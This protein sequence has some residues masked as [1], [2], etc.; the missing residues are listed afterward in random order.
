MAAAD[1]APRKTLTALV[2]TLAAIAVQ[3]LPIVAIDLAHIQTTSRLGAAVAVAVVIAAALVAWRALPEFR[4]RWLKR[5]SSFALL[6]WACLLTFLLGGS[7]LLAAP[8]ELRQ[9]VAL[10]G[11][12]VRAYVGCDGTTTDPCIVVRQ[13]WQVAPG[14]IQA[15][16][17]YRAWGRE[18]TLNIT[19]PN[20]LRI[21]APEFVGERRRPAETQELTLVAPPFPQ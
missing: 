10:G 11:Q 4:P 2:I 18:F 16:V 15:T 8:L 17:L 21:V 5:V 7:L 19:G 13:E 14:L 9:E 6:A 12:V 3:C 1:A 20:S